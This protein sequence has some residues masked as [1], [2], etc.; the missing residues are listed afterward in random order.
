MSVVHPV[1]SQQ[2]WIEARKALLLREKEMTH[3]RDAINR[4]QIGRAHV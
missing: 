4:E 1:V 3:L 2:E